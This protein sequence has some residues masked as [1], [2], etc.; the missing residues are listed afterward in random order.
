M[1]R[2]KSAKPEEILIHFVRTRVNATV[3]KRLEKIRNNGDCHTI[4]EVAR[5][6]L[7]KEQITVFYKDITLNSAMEELALIRKELRSIGININQLTRAY[8]SDKTVISQVSCLKD[9]AKCYQTVELKTDRLL[10]LINRLA[11]KWLPR[12]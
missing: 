8:H 3:F 6:I 10:S 4:A 11:E 1:P 9:I 5:K 12:S 2:K 7:S